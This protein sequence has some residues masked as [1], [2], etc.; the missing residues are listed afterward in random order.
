MTCSQFQYTLYKAHKIISDF[1]LNEINV[2][3]SR[4]TVPNSVCNLWFLSLKKYFVSFRAS[5]QWR[6]KVYAVFN[7][8]VVMMVLS[9][10]FTENVVSSVKMTREIIFLCQLRAWI[11]KHRF[12]KSCRKGGNSS[13]IKTRNHLSWRLN[14]RWQFFASVPSNLKVQLEKHIWVFWKKE[15][16]F[17]FLRNTKGGVTLTMTQWIACG[18]FLI[19]ATLFRSWNVTTKE[20]V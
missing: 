3:V 15:S 2:N 12:I 7:F 17:F 18:S 1:D 20:N 11:S 16:F 19:R 10:K 5:S 8:F 13:K 9:A 6:G 4:F 14:F